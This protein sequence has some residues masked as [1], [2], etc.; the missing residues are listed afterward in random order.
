MGSD[1]EAHPDSQA[2]YSRLGSNE[3]LIQSCSSVDWAVWELFNARLN[4]AS[5]SASSFCSLALISVSLKPGSGMLCANVFLSPK[6]I[7]TAPEATSRSVRLIAQD[8]ST[9]YDSHTYVAEIKS[10]AVTFKASQMPISCYFTH[11]P[12]P[13]CA[14][15][16]TRFE[17]TG[18]NVMHKV[19][20]IPF[21][22]Q[23]DRI[24][25]LFVTSQRRGHIRCGHICDNLGIWKN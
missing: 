10:G 9:L 11:Q 4:A 1:R 14:S 15:K 22:I 23:N 18:D 8:K 24:A 19:G 3:C 7:G 12:T 20:V 17:T 6:R 5:K 16:D 21:E 25:L 13:I 2:R